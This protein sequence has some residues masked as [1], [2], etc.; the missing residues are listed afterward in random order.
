MTYVVQEPSHIL[1]LRDSLHRFVERELPR[2]LVRHWDRERGFPVDVFRKLA[3]IGVCGLTIAEE[4]GG[5]GRDLVA[6][7]AT[8][9]ELARRG[10]IIAGPYIHCAFYGGLNISEHGSAA[11]KRDL[12]PKLARGELMFAYGLSEPDVGGDLASVTTGARLSA[13]GRSVILN[14]IKRWCTGARFADYILCL[15]KS[16]REAPRYKNL[17]FVLVPPSTSGVTV[18]DIDH[19]GLR[20]AAT[21]DVIFE[22]ATVPA[23]NILGGPE[24]W[25]LG[26]RQLAGPSARRRKTRDHCHRLRDSRGSRG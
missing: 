18:H 16:D 6:A 11:Q 13:D 3:A 5:A 15:V 14:G 24:M 25:N 1:A 19:I 7:V 17:S 9:D 8:I 2:E 21:T 4:Y 10:A 20:Y 23:E 12:L 22:D 26:W